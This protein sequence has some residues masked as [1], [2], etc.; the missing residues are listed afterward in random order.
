LAQVSYDQ[1]K[2]LLPE[3]FTDGDMNNVP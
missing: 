2:K 3:A 1:F